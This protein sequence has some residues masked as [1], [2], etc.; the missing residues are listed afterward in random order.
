MSRAWHRKDHET[1]DVIV[2]GL[3]YVRAQIERECGMSRE[4]AERWMAA[5]VGRPIELAHATYF[6]GEPE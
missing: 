5:M 1:G 6:F 2:V 3:T 4:E